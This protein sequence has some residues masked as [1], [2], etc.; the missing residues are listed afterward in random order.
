MSLRTQLGAFLYDWPRFLRHI[1]GDWEQIRNRDETL[2]SDGR[3]VIC[4]WEFSS[5][6]HIAR[7]SPFA[8]RWLFRRAFADWPIARRDA[9][10]EPIRAPEVSFIIGHRGLE[11][12]PNLLETLRSIAGQDGAAI[13]CIVVEQSASREV[14]GQLPPWVRY[15]HTP[16][17]P[18]M[19]YCRSATFNAGAAVA[20]GEVLIL[21]D[22]DILV[23]ER[24]AAEVLARVREGAR[25]VDLKRFLFYLAEDETL[26]SIEQNLQGGSIAAT[27][28]AYAAVGGFDEGF[29]GWGGEDNDFRERAH[30]LGGVYA[31]G[32]LPMIHLWHPP[33]PGKRDAAAPAVR[34]YWEEI[35]HIPAEERIRRL[36]K[37]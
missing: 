37:T 30:A 4:Q 26:T 6:L 33:Q 34:R 9:L 10:Q 31:F 29:I 3:G 21:H 12:L 17:P 13:E 19:P 23:P 11:R 8:A 18:D 24:Y 27:R 1:G 16:V 15:V 25:F 20:R 14:E 5:E 32:Y 36:T 35:R 28:Q 22:N 2:L 7:V